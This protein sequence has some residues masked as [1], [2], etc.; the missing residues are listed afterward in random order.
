MKK[1]IIHVLF[2]IYVVIAVFVTVCLLSYNEF[3]ITEF[4]DSS[5]IIIDSNEVEPDFQK[6]DLVI[7]NKNDKI[8]VGD[9]VFFYNTYQKEVEVAIGKVTNLEKITSS[10]TT[11]TI[12]G[13]EEIVL[14]SEYI[15]GTAEDATKIPNVGT[16]LGI[17][18]SKWGFL[19]LI[20]FPSLI[21]FLYEIGVVVSE[22]KDAKKEEGK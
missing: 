11:Y 8:N 21:A 13:E 3:K 6:G 20:V 18:E 4:G 1:I 5:L 19:F 15:I 2:A 14:S 7:A 22:I 16:I 10:E 12:S 9:N 17:L